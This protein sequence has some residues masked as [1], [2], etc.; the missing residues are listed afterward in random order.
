MS[1][2]SQRLFWSAPA[3]RRRGPRLGGPA[4]V[5][6]ATALWVRMVIIQ[7]GVAHRL[8]PHSKERSSHE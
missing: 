3:E 1:F 8:P 6:A 5:L 7:S 2:D 4:G